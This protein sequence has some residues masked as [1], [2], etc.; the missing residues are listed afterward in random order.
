MFRPHTAWTF[1]TPVLALVAL[2]AALLPASA[3]SHA[4]P[5]LPALLLSDIHFDPFLD[6]G[7]VPQLASAPAAGW[8]AILDAPPSADHEARLAVLEK[9]C[10]TR[11]RD[12]GQELFVS[13]LKQIHTSAHNARFAVI[14]GDF[15]AHAFDCKFDA[16]FPKAPEVAYRAFTVKTMEYILL[17]VRAALPGVPVYP[18]LG[19]NDS[20]CGDY[21]LDPHSPF[22]T[23]SAKSFVADVPANQRAAAEADFAGFGNYSVALPAPFQH[24]RIV[25]IDDLFESKRYTG[26][27]AKPNPTAAHEQLAWLT[28]QLK[29]A[30]AQGEKLWIVGH[31]PPGIDP[32]STATHLRNI[33]A[34]QKPEAFLS[35]GALPEALAPYSDVISLAIFAHTHMDEMRLIPGADKHPPIAA[36]LTPSISP[37]NGNLPSFT[38]ARV[39]PASGTLVDYSVV[40]S[41]DVKGSSWARKYGFHE[42]YQLSAYTAATVG[43]LIAAFEADKAA[44]STLS[45]AYIKNYY[46]RS[47]STLMTLFWPIYSCS[48]AHMDPASF[49]N[50]M[51]SEGH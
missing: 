2:L 48:L 45:Q 11:G 37:I 24:L 17:Q 15:L 47:S 27:N 34:G 33:C 43:Q 25:A 9:S 1:V 12:T 28:A 22:L 41:S 51:C 3:Q 18:V 32:Y 44:D 20:G 19:N 5:E 39:N 7:K 30:R 29:A 26:C 40:A 42:A 13:S 14:A 10:H 50:C 8:R 23:E 38:L 46:F 36:K 6:P 16:V 31:I 35:S 49:Q 21:Q 4:T